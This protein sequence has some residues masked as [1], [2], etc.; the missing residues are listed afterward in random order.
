MTPE[1]SSE[2][3]EFRAL[4]EIIIQFSDSP[5]GVRIVERLAPLTQPSKIQIQFALIGEWLQLI[6]AGQNP[7]FDGVVDCVSVFEKLRIEGAVLDTQEILSV[8]RLLHAAE[9]TKNLLRAVDENCPNLEQ[10]GRQL[11]SLTHLIV[12][13]EGKINEFGEVDDHASHELKRLRNEVNIVRG[14]LYR[15]LEEIS[16]KHDGTQTL[17]DEVITIRNDR[18]VIPVRTEKRRELAG[19]VHG[20]SSSGLTIFVEPL[21]TIE[22]NNHLVRLQE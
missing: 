12:L 19:V 17:Q 3:L 7:R 15:S 2:L 10:V 22:L 16:R 13:I 14:R 11:P 4:I 8:S 9:S 1:Y 5:L 18:F 21:E 20:T 6:E